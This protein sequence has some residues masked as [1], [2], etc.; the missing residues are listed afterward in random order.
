MT[1]VAIT[2]V[3]R[4]LCLGLLAAAAGCVPDSYEGLTGGERPLVE[5]AALRA[6]RPLSPVSVSM[7]ATSRPRFRWELAQTTGAVVEMCRTRACEGESPKRFFGQGQELVVDQDLEPGMWFWRLRGANDGAIGTDT[8]PTWQVLVR[9]PAKN[10]ASTTPTG[11]VMDIDG[12][13]RPDLLA[14][15]LAPDG[16]DK[17]KLFPWIVV[18][19]G[20]ADGTFDTNEAEIT[21]TWS[22]SGQQYFASPDAPAEPPVAIAGGTDFNGDGFADF[23]TAGMDVFPTAK[24]PLYAVTAEFGSA[25]G[26]TD[27][28]SVLDVT[29]WIYPG[30]LASM[31]ASGDVNGDGYGDV[32][33]GG[34]DAAFVVLGTKLGPSAASVLFPSRDLSVTARPVLGAFDPDGDGFSEVAVATPAFGQGSSRHGGGAVVRPTRPR[35]DAS[36]A[37]A[38]SP[39]EGELSSE[40]AL[41][42]RWSE[43][44]RTSA[45]HGLRPREAKSSA[46]PAARAFATGDFDGDGLSDVAASDTSGRV[47]FW[48]GHR[49][50]LLVPG[51]CARGLPGDLEVGSSLAAADLEGDGVDELLVV[52]RKGDV[53]AIRTMRLDGDTVNVA[54]IP[55]TEGAGVSLTTLWPGRPGKARWAAALDDG[56]AI[57][58]FEGVTRR[59]RIE[60]PPGSGPRFGAALR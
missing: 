32:A 17:T 27:I 59:Q 60:K 36:V 21:G 58:V 46:H 30:V 12:D 43:A 6:P 19:K 55:D 22:S 52:A 18:F 14:S 4:A 44:S 9:G 34:D 26:W 45:F 15:T 35:L 1:R 57:A 2:G 48:F 39:L 20:G 51:P 56:R 40:V 37:G 53:H 5:D 42:A 24:G 25:K 23:A 41:V 54:E 47:C 33:V 10:G 49:E 13:G 7:V 3:G 28:G 50:R 38:A 29:G 16:D 8:S 31:A 11:T